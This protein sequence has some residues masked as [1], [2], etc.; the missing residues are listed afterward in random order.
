MDEYG[1]TVVRY[2]QG[3]PEAVGAKYCKA[4]VVGGWKSVEQRWNDTARGK[5]KH[6]E[7]NTVKKEW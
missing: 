5:V 6:W 3:K 2:W 7:K 1:R 4:W